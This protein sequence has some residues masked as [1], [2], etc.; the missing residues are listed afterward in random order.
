MSANSA[1][2]WTHHTFNPWWGC[3]KISDGC[4]HCYAESDAK[5]YGHDVWGIDT[6]RRFFGEK[7]WKQP[8]VWNERARLAGVRH[9]VFCASMADVFEDRRDLDPWR[10]KLL[11]LI[12]VTPQLDWLLLTKRPENIEPLLERVLDEGHHSTLVQSAWPAKN[13]AGR[14]L[15]GGAPRNVWLG[16]T[17]ESQEMLDKRGPILVKIPAVVRFFSAEPLLTPLDVSGY[18]QPHAVGIDWIIVGGES[19][20]KARPFHMDWAADIIEAA[21]SF[22]PVRTAVFVK[23]MGDRPMHGEEN[24]TLINLGRKGKDTER[25]PP[26]LVV[27]QFPVPRRT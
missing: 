15:S 13:M 10:V 22:D 16:T 25:W 5:R 2:E 24:P 23:Q 3:V 1:I 4:K 7:H 27:R 26:H 11:D 6:S 8:L 18:V 19:G 17:T 20:G 21:Q 14:W 12:S 9:R